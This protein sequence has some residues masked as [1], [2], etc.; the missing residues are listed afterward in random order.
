[1]SQKV[2][3]N[4]VMGRVAALAI[5]EFCLTKNA[6]AQVSPFIRRGCPILYVC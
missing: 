3:R 5:E 2:I 6:S 4:I 1:M